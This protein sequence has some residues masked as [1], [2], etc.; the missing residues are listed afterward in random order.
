V[1]GIT[2]FYDAGVLYG[3]TLRNL[4]M[5][6]AL[7]GIVRCPGRRFERRARTGRFRRA[8]DRCDDGDGLQIHAEGQQAAIAVLDYKFSGLPWRVGELA[9][10]LDAVACEFGEKRVCIF[11][12]EIGV[13]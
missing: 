5:H 12:P 13:K 8:P 3:S 1:P 4:L 9:G 7:T 10:E 6:L 2:A 11:D